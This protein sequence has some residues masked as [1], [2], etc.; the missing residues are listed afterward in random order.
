MPNPSRDI[1]LLLIYTKVNREALLDNPMRAIPICLP[2]LS[3]EFKVNV[4]FH[5][6]PASTMKLAI[7]M[8]EQEHP[9]M[10]GAVVREF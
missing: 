4:F 8:E 1:N 3:E 6:D 5:V 7:V 2:G 9:E 10:F